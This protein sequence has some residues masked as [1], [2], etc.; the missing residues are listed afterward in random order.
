MILLDTH[1][2]IWLVAEPESLS[3]RATVAIGN[4]ERSKTTIGISAASIYEMVNGYR[5]GRVQ[6]AAPQEILLRHIRSRLQII[7]I[8]EEIAITAGQIPEPFHGDPMDRFI[9]ATAIVHNCT[10]ITGDR[11]ILRAKICKTL[12]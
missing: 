11:Q 4:A 5:L 12:W 10:L 2:F 9:V 7:P 1:T 8:E 3:K 6:Y